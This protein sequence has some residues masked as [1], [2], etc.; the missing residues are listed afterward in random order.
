MA[1]SKPYFSLLLGAC[2]GVTITSTAYFHRNMPLSPDS[3]DRYQYNLDETPGSTTFMS[4]K[5]T[6]SLADQPADD[7]YTMRQYGQAEVPRFVPEWEKNVS[8]LIQEDYINE[9]KKAQK[10]A[11]PEETEYPNYY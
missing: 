6:R 4:Y 10:K 2:T 3:R 1:I 9:Q 11:E 5:N 8:A 7:D